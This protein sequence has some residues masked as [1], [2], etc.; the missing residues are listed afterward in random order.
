[1]GSAELAYC[2]LDCGRCDCRAKTNCP[3]CQAAGGRMFWGECQ[4]A[5]CCMGKGLA[6]CG[7][8][9]EFPCDVLKEFAYSKEHGDN[10]QRIER[11]KALA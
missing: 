7:K 3:G 9:D 2:G 8:C 11:L 4:V 6:H 10:G 1:M 5:T